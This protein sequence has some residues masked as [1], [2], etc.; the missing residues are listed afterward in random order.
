MRKIQ[1]TEEEAERYAQVFERSAATQKKVYHDLRC[2][3]DNRCSCARF[4]QDMNN[5]AKEMRRSRI[6]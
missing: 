6:I 2:K 1:L 5:A 4:V 3:L